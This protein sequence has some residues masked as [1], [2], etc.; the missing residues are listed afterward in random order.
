MRLAETFVATGAKIALHDALLTAI[1][2][3]F[4]GFTITAMTRHLILSGL[5][6]TVSLYR[7]DT[8]EGFG[9]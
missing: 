1:E 3:D 7:H 8:T 9:L 4:L 2:S 6:L 5:A